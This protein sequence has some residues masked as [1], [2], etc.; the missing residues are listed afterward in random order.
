MTATVAVNYGNG[1]VSGGHWTNIANIAAWVWCPARIAKVD[2]S[3]R[4]FVVVTCGVS[5]ILGVVIRGKYGFRFPDESSNTITVS[6]DDTL[7]VIC[8]TP[9]SEKRY[10]KIH[11]VSALSYTE[12]LLETQKT[13]VVTCDGSESSQK[14]TIIGVRRFSPLP[15]SESILFEPGETYY[16]IA[17]SS[18]EKKGINQTQYGM[19]A[20][21]NMRLV[22][23]VRAQTESSGVRATTERAR[24]SEPSTRQFD[25]PVNPKF[26]AIAHSLASY[27]QRR[28]QKIPDGFTQEQ[29]QK[30]AAL[31]QKGATGTFTFDTPSTEGSRE[32]NR[33]AESRA[34]SVFWDTAPLIE[35]V[36]NGASDSILLGTNR[37]GDEEGAFVVHE[38][39]VR[40]YEYQ[41]NGGRPSTAAAILSSALII[42]VYRFLL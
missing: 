40:S 30:V 25:S 37:I 28:E 13:L 6:M 18:G 32:D 26:S 23:H 16:W 17:T 22:I 2:R 1:Q 36:L 19:C 29:L 27:P 33:D 11:K 21:D 20:A 38:D 14:P 7:R 10:L 34:E 31:A 35:N 3:P 15:S 41:S 9:E 39:V 8:P 5:N 24:S 12:C 4:A 42:L